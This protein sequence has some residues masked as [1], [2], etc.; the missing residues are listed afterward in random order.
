MKICI[1]NFNIYCLFNPQ[2]LAPM[3]GAELDMY[4]IAK[5]LENIHDVSMIA[6]DWGQKEIEVF[7]GIRII[8]TFPLGK[9]GVYRAI[10]RFFLFWK[11][12]SYADA[13]VY[14][15]SGAGADVGVIA[16]FCRLKKRRFIYRTAHLI[17]CD[18]S[19]VKKNGLFGMIYEY[20]LQNASKIVTSV[21]QH[22]DIL[23]DRYP[24]FFGKIHHINLGIFTRDVLLDKKYVLWV[25]RCEKWKKPEIFL[26]IAKIL[27]GVSFVMICPKQENDLIYF[28]EIKRKADELSNVT[29]IE[30]VPFKDI[31]PYF[32]KAKVFINTS[33][34]EGFTYTLIQS[35]LARTPV[36]YLNVNPDEVITK[37]AIGYVSDNNKEKMS[38]QIK[39]LLNDEKDWKEKSENAFQYVKK[40]HD[41]E[42]VGKQWVE[43][44]SKF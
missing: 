36:V 8:R 42:T 26:E 20:G 38:E 2:S 9:R 28:E 29:F 37:H 23:I 3:G 17:D 10:R 24:D 44:V 7:G 27:D 40:N 1:V 18:G 11:K 25:A 35:G 21:R 4:T 41:I 31:Q 16:F 32:D 13:D 15:S 43:L 39:I 5:E 33:D 14:I 6:G 22:K 30:S 12:L 34:A 19:Y